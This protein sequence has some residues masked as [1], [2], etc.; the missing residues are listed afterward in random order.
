[1][2][3]VSILMKYRSERL[4]RLASKNAGSV[5]HSTVKFTPDRVCSCA[6]TMH[7]RQHIQSELSPIA[8]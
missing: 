8:W 4:S 1:V 5:S 6:H 7:T 2:T 3:S